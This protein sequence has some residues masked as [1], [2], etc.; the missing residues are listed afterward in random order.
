MKPFL[1][2]TI[3]F[4]VNVRAQSDALTADFKRFIS[5]SKIGS[6]TEQAYCYLKDN[7]IHGYQPN[8]MQR[9]ASVTK[10]FSTY[11]ISETENLH[12]TYQTKVFIGADAIHIEGGRD[13]YF[14]EDKLLLLF[15]ALN[16]LGITN[17]RQVSFNKDFLFYDLALG[18]YEIITPEKTRARLSAYLN[19]SNAGL[20]RSRWL[21]IKKFAA[22]EGVIL[23]ERIPA[24]ISSKVIISDK[25][26]LDGE[27][28]K[29]YIHKSKPLHA[30]LKTMN[31]QSKNYV[32]ENI[33]LAGSS[34]RKLS[35]LFKEKGISESTYRI[36]NGS[37]LPVLGTKRMDNLATCATVLEVTKLLEQSLMKQKLKL[38]D[39]IAVNG[40]KDLGSF[41]DRFTDYPETHESV[42]SKTG[43]LKHTSSLAG[44]LATTE[45]I[46]FAVLNHTSLA[47]PARRFQDQFVARMFDFI[48]P[49]VPLQYNKISIFPWDGSQFLKEIN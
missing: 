21:S 32:A 27:N 5:Q 19:P 44:F 10:L 6:V 46:P 9:I 15:E 23:Q 20:R 48:G 18:S 40:G 29:V 22:E 37:G 2:F 1:I 26:P 49:A 13:P 35:S 31:V 36:Y 4:T 34:F 12:R 25:N 8:K 17:L 16:D 38:S 39:V 47:T 30:L 28:P 11:L 3:L 41:R 45:N 24:I 33:Y 7:K 42:L 43:T 14:E